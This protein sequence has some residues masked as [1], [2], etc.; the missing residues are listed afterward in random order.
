MSF[1]SGLSAQNVSF[2]RIIVFIFCFAIVD[3]V[4]SA[5]VVIVF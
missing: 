3:V 4:Y 1:F 5:F 2:V